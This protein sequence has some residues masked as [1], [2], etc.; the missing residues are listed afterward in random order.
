RI[1]FPSEDA[2]QPQD[3]FPPFPSVRIFDPTPYSEVLYDQCGN[4][5]MIYQ[6]GHGLSWYSQHDKA[7]HIVAQG[8][9][10]N[11]LPRPEPLWVPPGDLYTLD[12]D[13]DQR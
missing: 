5:A 13:L 2:R 7:D 12:R 8:Y 9:L 4:S 1:L 10:F 3:S 11:P 6:Q